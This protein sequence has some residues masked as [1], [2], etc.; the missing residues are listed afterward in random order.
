MP[1]W[2]NVIG[3]A[4]AVARTLVEGPREK[5]TPD[6]YFWTEA[7]GIATDECEGVFLSVDID[8]CDPGHAPARAAYEKAGFRPF[9]QVRYYRML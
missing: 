6:P 8:V 4:K 7:F 9:P 5:Y 3:Q 1:H 2:E